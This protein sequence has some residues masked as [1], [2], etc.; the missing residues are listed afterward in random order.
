MRVYLITDSE[1]LKVKERYFE[2]ILKDNLDY[3]LNDIKKFDDVKTKY[4]SILSDKRVIGRIFVAYR[5]FETAVIF[6][7]GSGIMPLEAFLTLR[8]GLEWKVV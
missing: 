4:Y 2:R 5:R 7:D 6:L 3:F 1:G 8:K